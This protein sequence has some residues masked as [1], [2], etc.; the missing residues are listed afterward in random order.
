MATVQ[1]ALP[2]QIMVEGVPLKDRLARVER[3]KKVKAFLLVT[4]LLAFIVITFVIPIADMLYRSV[5]NPRL[6]T[7]MPQTMAILNAW[8]GK[9]LPPEAAFEALTKEILALR[10]SGDI[11]KVSG[12]VNYDMSGARSLF[13]KTARKM[14]K[15]KGGPYKEAVIKADKRWGERETWAIIKLAG[16]KTT[17]A[18]YLAAVDRQLNADGEVVLKPDERRIYVALFIRTFWISAAVTLICLLMGYPI[19]YLMSTQPV[20]ISNL[21]IIMVLLPF[22]TSLL[23]RTTSWIVLLQTKGVI[24]DVLVWIGI[25][26]EDGRIQM[27]YN[28]TGTLI[29]MSQILLPFMVLPL[30]SVMKTIPISQVRAAQSLGA[31]PFVAFYQI[32]FPQSVPGIGAGGLL[33]F[34]LSVGYYITPA[35]VGGSSGQ[36][37]SNMIAFHMKSSLNWGLAAALGTMLLASVLVFYYVYD[38]VVGIDRMKLG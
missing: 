31:N 22:W 18:F 7:L 30:Y 10:K 19:A 27:I 1:D 2:G 5:D 23:V 16:K 28:Q 21:L 8:D 37:I 29:A 4:P 9:D 32:F 11:G 3:S 17:P 13:A 6:T 25:I 15:V 24:N 14:K 33:V 34:V 35:L 36:L 38:K 26:S 12:R 20:R